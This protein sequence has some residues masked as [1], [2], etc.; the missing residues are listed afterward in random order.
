[1]RSSEQG[2]RALRGK[3]ALRWGRK[4]ERGAGGVLSRASLELGRQC[5]D[6]AMVMKRR[7]RRSSVTAVLKLG[8][9]G[10]RGGG[11]AVRSGGGQLLL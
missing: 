11:G 3:G 10:K 4:R 8:G 2:L 7:R 6:Q 1:M 5:G 9:R